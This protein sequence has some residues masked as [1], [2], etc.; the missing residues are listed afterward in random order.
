MSVPG[1]GLAQRP[2]P[3]R[4]PLDRLKGPPQEVQHSA[5]DQPGTG[6]DWP[7]QAVLPDCG[8]LRR[9]V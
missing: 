3:V 2:K 4:A 6:T 7:R 8:W 5:G 1:A 9:R